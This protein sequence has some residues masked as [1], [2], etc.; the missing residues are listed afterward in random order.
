MKFDLIASCLLERHQ[1]PFKVSSP[2]S[3]LKPVY[4]AHFQWLDRLVSSEG[5]FPEFRW[6]SWLGSVWLR[7]PHLR[8]LIHYGGSL[9][10]ENSQ[11]WFWWLALC[12][13]VFSLWCWE[14]QEATDRR[15][16]SSWG[17]GEKHSGAVTSAADWQQA[18]YTDPRLCQAFDIE[19]GPA[20]ASMHSGS[21]EACCRAQK[22]A[23][24][25]LRSPRSFLT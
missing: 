2:E 24:R 8:A 5:L 20:W 11:L 17:R 9:G 21:S 22:P 18:V 12:T 3:I 16:C 13:G 6:F 23:V 15:L 10:A 1:L 19:V 14:A 4:R 7:G 25:P